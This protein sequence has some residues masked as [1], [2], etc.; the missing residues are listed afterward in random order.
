MSKPGKTWKQ[1]QLVSK[2]LGR[3]GCFPWS[4]DRYVGSFCW[5]NSLRERNKHIRCLESWICY[6]YC[7]WKKSQTT[8]WDVYNPINN[9]DIYHMNWLA[10]FQPSTVFHLCLARISSSN[11]VS[12]W[13]VI[14]W[15]LLVVDW[16]GLGI[17]RLT[18]KAH[19][20]MEHPLTIYAPW[21]GNIWP[22]YLPTVHFSWK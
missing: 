14:F 2:C 13:E 10:G 18:K 16:G 1:M 17:M 22:E 21:D 7:W 15:P 12:Q 3:L 9:G 4:G 20:A 8:T 5:S 11:K 6:T 19:N